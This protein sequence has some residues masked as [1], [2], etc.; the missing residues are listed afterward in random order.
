MMFEWLAGRPVAHRGFHDRAARRIENSVSAA[1]A[2]IAHGY[3]IECDVQISADGQAMVFHDF[4][5]ERLTGAQGRVDALCARDLQALTLSNADDVIPTLES[6]LA[7]IAGAT[8]VICEIKSAFDGDLRL[9]ARAAQIAAVYAG[10][11]ALKSFDPNVIAFLR[12]EAA[13]LGV[14]HVPLGIVAE[15]GFAGE[16]WTFLSDEQRLGMSTLTHW[17]KTAPDFL[18]WRVA[19]LPHATPS[20]CRAYGVPVLAWTVRTREGAARAGEFADQMIFEGFEA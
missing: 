11:I 8:P 19:D 4:E 3:A 18:S 14:P 13:E 15:A 9:A 20:L 5:L 1:R 2:A 7:D 16:A 10:P 6:W 12:R 17:S